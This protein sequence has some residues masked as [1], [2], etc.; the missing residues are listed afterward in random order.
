MKWSTVRHNDNNNWKN[1]TKTSRFH[2]FSHLQD[3]KNSR[4]TNMQMPL[5][6]TPKRILRLQAVCVWMSGMQALVN[7]V[8]L[9]NMK[10]VV[11]SICILVIWEF[12]QSWRCL[13]WRKSIKALFLQNAVTNEIKNVPPIQSS[14]R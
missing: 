3:S 6:Q 4:I 8:F 10:E 1:R 5:L 12:S 9:S 7:F 11:C 14:S 2:Q 13:N